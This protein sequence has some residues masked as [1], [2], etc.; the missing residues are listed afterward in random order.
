MDKY[1]AGEIRALFERGQNIIDWIASREGMPN[2]ESAILY[3]YDA[4]AG[5]YVEELKDNERR[6]FRNE[7][8]RLIAGVLDEL[9][10]SSLLEAGVGEA[11][12][13]VPILSHMSD[14]PTHVLGLD[15][16]FSRLLYARQY[17]AHCRQD[18][19]TLFTAGLDRIPL[20]SNSVDVVLTVH[21]VE[22]NRG[23]ER[24]ILSELLRVAR[25][26]LVMIE[27]SYEF[28][29]PE[30]KLRMDRLGYVRGL[31]EMLKR[32]GHAP[33]I[34]KPWPLSGNPLNPASLIIVDKPNDAAVQPP[35]FISPISGGNLTLRS[36]CWFC[37]DDGHAFPFIARIPCLTISSAI[38]ASKLNSFGD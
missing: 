23:R 10:P 32:I 17:I 8:G 18:D 13:L 27:P 24:I 34:V 11:T 15:L 12:T 9:A 16:S 19:V 2:S 14:R 36:D 38:L 20:A 26:H 7:L 5:T 35:K 4:Q 29:S 22:P 3:S 30:G 25:R 28:A 1:S 31:P 21:S 6:H 37:P 33:R